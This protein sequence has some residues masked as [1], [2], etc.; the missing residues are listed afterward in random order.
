MHIHLSKNILERFPLLAR[1]FHGYGTWVIFDIPIILGSFVLALL[2]RAFTANLDLRSGLLFTLLVLGAFLY[3]NQLMGIYRRYWSYATI[4]DVIALFAASSMATAA[5]MIAELFFAPRPLPFS[6]V[7]VG[8]FF[9]FAGMTAI[10]LRRRLFSGT[11]L[12]LRNS[13]ARLIAQ[14]TPTLIVGA[15]ESG[16]MLAFHMQ[17]RP[18]GLGYHLVGFVDDD[19]EK[20]GKFLHGVPVFGPCERLPIIAAQRKVELIVLAI[21]NV[22]QERRRAL[23]DLCLATDARVRILPD[24][25]SSLISRDEP[26]PLRKVTAQDLLGR[27]PR[28]V[29]PQPIRCLLAGRRVLITGACGS[30]GAELARQVLAVGPEQLILLDN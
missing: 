10:R 25:L 17:M 3:A 23:I 1:F 20:I 26:L 4:H 30:I 7:I 19:P 5:V 29:A 22:E 9:S 8:G 28:K 21:H 15:G 18:S 27:S 14:G 2:G 6:V 24:P 11:K 13:L 16:Q 12:A